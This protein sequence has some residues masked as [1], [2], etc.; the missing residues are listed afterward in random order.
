MAQVEKTGD[1]SYRVSGVIDFTTVMSLHTQFRNLSARERN[2]RIDLGGLK[3]SNSAGLGF[4]MEILANAAKNGQVLQIENVPDSLMD[5]AAMCNV[6]G[7]IRP[8]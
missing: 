7:L 1:G 3:K 6:D 5:L 4:L 2:I 8:A